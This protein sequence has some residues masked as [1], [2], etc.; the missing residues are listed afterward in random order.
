MAIPAPLAGDHVCTHD[1]LAAIDFEAVP[2]FLCDDGIGPGTPELRENFKKML[3]DLGI[4]SRT[5][6]AV[7]GKSKPELIEIVRD[8]GAGAENE[9]EDTAIG[10]AKILSAGS[11]NAKRLYELIH[12]AELRTM[13]SL[14]NCCHDDDDREAVQ[15]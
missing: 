4:A 12:A 5:A 11:D 1:E 6:M 2:E 9:E 3:S 14:A 10:L 13:C 7:L 15:S 8:L